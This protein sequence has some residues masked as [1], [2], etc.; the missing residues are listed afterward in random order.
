MQ[1]LLAALLV[2]TLASAC[3]EQGVLR[4]R[5]DDY[6]KARVGPTLQLPATLDDEA[7]QD[8]YVIPPSTAGLPQPGAS[9]VPRPAPLT[10][11]AADELVRI[12]RLGTE[13]WMLVGFAPGRLWPR[14]RAFLSAN[15][16]QVARVDAR[17]GLI[18]SGWLRPEGMEQDERYQFRI[19]QGVQRNTAELHVRQMFLHGDKNHWPEQSSALEREKEMLM[20]VAEYIAA[21]PEE[22]S[23]SLMAQEQISDDGRVSMQESE[24]G[25]PYIRLELPFYR[26]WASVERALG[27]SGFTTRDL[28]RSSGRYY[29]RHDASNR[30]GGS[31]FGGDDDDDLTEQDFVLELEDQ[32]EAVNIR[33]SREDGEL[34]LAPQAQS[35]LVLIKGNIS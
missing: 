8:I 5:S 1:Q 13:E 7:L 28:D 6:R 20:A 12:Q 9:E 17:A 35:L 29:I 23:V 10:A 2:L 31:W 22:A 30:E 33:I 15:S 27:E 19:E 26:A 11:R 14:V 32:G 21:S 18:E 25:E 4:D 16:L 3:S 24:A 34:L